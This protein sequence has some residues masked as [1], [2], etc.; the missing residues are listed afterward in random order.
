MQDR[1][2]VITM[3]CVPNVCIINNTLSPKHDAMVPFN[4]TYLHCLQQFLTS[5]QIIWPYKVFKY[6]SIPNKTS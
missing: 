3:H 2:V 5:L 4:L 1:H 6:L